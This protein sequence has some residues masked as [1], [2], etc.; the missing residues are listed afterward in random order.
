MLGNEQEAWLFRNLANARARW[1]L[2]GQQVYSFAKDAARVNPNGRFGMDTWN[3]YVAGARAPLRPHRR[4]AGAEPGRDLGRHPR[5]LRRGPEAGLHEHVVA[6]NRGRA[7][8]HVDYAPVVTDRRSAACGGRSRIDNPHI[9]F[10]SQRRGYISCTATPSAMRAEF[11]T[12]E[13]VTMPD[14]PTR[15]RPHS[16][17]RPAGRA[18]RRADDHWGRS[19]RPREPEQ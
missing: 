16:W 12:L 13:R 15:T 14:L 10:H 3:G 19:S 8:E 6:D 7:H 18:C 4:N 5:A 9:K 2:I 1:T 11:K 17:W